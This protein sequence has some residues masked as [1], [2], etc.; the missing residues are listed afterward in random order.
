MRRI[1]LVSH[2]SDKETETE[3]NK[4]PKAIYLISGRTGI[5]VQEF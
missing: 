1:L 4:L 2:F 5:Q 3:K